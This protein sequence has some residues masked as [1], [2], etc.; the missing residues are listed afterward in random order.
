LSRRKRRSPRFSSAVAQVI[1]RT[2]KRAA[3]PKGIQERISPHW[4]RHAHASHALDNKAP[5]SLVQQTLG[6]GSLKTTSIYAH[7]KPGDSSALYLKK[8]R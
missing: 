4:L 7:A 5:I 8:V 3:L 6:H 2:A 1:K